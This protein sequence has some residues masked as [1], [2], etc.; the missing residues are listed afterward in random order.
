MAGSKFENAAGTVADELIRGLQLV[1]Q[2][3]RGAETIVRTT[4]PGNDRDRELRQY[5]N[6][7][8]SK[9]SEAFSEFKICRGLRSTRAQFTEMFGSAKF[10]TSIGTGETIE[11]LLS[12]LES[13]ERMII[14]E[15]GPMLQDLRN[16]VSAAENKFYA[17]AAK[18][19]VDLS[20]RENRVRHLAR[21]VHD[22]M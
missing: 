4:A 15:V 16:H 14:D 5:L 12:E 17:A 21:E 22:K 6:E 11:R 3:I 8:E 20:R 19:I 10:A 2:R 13:D 18:H 9:L 1:A 7:S